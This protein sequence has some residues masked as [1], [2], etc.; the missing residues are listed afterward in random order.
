MHVNA[1][2]SNSE[3]AE[4]EKINSSAVNKPIIHTA[5]DFIFL[6]S[7]YYQQHRDMTPSIPFVTFHY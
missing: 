2:G 3:S 4:E 6:N 7:E 1:N 5:V